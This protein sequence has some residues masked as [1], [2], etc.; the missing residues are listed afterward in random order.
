MTFTPR[1]S[2]TWSST[3][4]QLWHAYACAAMSA[5]RSWSGET[6]SGAAAALA[7]AMLVEHH[8]RFPPPQEGP[9]R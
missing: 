6:Q 3:D 4:E 9:Y 1:T 2:H 5:I 8:K 7:D